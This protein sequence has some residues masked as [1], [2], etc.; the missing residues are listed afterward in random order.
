[1]KVLHITSAGKQSGAGKGVLNLHN[2]LRRLGVDS[3]ILFFVD[4]PNEAESIF[5]ISNNR[6]NKL[7]RLFITFLDNFFLKFYIKRKKQLFSPGIIGFNLLDHSLVQEANIIHFHWVNHGL[8]D[9]NSLDRLGKPIVWTMRDMWA[10]TGGCHYA[11]D[12]DGYKNECIKCPV[13]NTSTTYLASYCQKRKEQAFSKTIGIRWIAISS[14]LK[15]LAASSRILRSQNIEVINSGV[16]YREFK[17]VERQ[18]AREKLLVRKNASVI[19]LGAQNMSDPYKGLEFAIEAINSLEQEVIVILFGSPI[20][21]NFNSHVELINVG[22]VSNSLDLSFLYSAANLF[23]CPSIAEAF[24]KTAVEAQMCG[25]PVVCFE[26]TGPS[27]IVEHLKT[28]YK[29]KFKSV[30]SLVSGLDFVLNSFFDKEY[31]I[32]R[33]KDNFSIDQNAIDYLKIYKELNSK[34]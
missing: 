14:W 24:G 27:E 12:C 22:Y 28:G 26:S 25:V 16:D 11:L 21:I 34:G 20:E 33:A 32:N 18:V 23:L 4:M 29:A 17:P 19:L 6:N 30:T 5:T 8:V 2:A 1:M 15:T 13:L 31:I 10:F 9:L 7:K 3:Q